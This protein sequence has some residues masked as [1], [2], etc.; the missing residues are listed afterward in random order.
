MINNWRLESLAVVATGE[1]RTTPAALEV[2]AVA[3]AAPGMVAGFV[4]QKRLFVAA[5]LAL[6]VTTALVAHQVRTAAVT[7]NRP[8]QLRAVGS[9]AGGPHPAGTGR[10]GGRCGGTS[11][12][13][14]PIDG[15]TVSNG[16]AVGPFP[17]TMPCVVRFT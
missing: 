5:Q 6:D 11:S 14:R 10:C 16:E 8:Q 13:G 2:H 15:H 3:W 7:A 12:D 9:G 17:I 1:P 4:R